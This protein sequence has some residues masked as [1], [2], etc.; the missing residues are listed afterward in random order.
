MHAL[1]GNALQA[2]ALRLFFYD[3]DMHIKTHATITMAAAMMTTSASPNQF[4]FLLQKAWLL[5][6]IFKKT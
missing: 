1:L 5:G 6:D 2:A 3:A 4:S